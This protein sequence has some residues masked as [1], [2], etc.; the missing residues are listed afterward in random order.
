MI[1]EPFLTVYL[2]VTSKNPVLREH[3][4]TSPRSGPLKIAQHLSAGTR[5]DLCPSPCSG[6]LR[7]RSTLDSSSEYS[8]VRFTDWGP[9]TLAVPALKC[10]ATV[11]RPLHGLGAFNI[12]CPSTQVLGYCQPSASRTDISY[13]LR[14]SHLCDFFLR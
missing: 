2:S 14:K 7:K 12:G 6:R 10:W 9:S 1:P 13:S 3:L 8:V 4:D 11:S 5:Q